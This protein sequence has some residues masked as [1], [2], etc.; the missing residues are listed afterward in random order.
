MTKLL[1]LL[2]FLDFTHFKQTGYPCIG[3]K[4]YSFQRGPVPK[5]FWLEIRDG[6][7]PEDFRDKLALI[8][9]KDDLNQDFREIEFQAK[10]NPDLSIFSPRELE[11]LDNLAFVFKDARAWEM[12]EVT[13]LPQQPWDTTIREKGKNRLIDYLLAIDEESEVDLEDA[14]ESLK[15]HFEVLSNFQLEPSK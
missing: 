7:V 15:E 11:I 1:K 2:Y 4:Y 9:R 3:L 14:R 5:D 13:H 6:N 10:A 12:A 8:P